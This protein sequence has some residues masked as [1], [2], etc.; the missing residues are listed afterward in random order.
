M[1]L[2]PEAGVLPFVDSGTPMM[3]WSLSIG[4]WLGL[5][6]LRAMLFY[7][8]S[9]IHVEESSSGHSELGGLAGDA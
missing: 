6:I 7:F 5:I 3:M 4:V 2:S 9:V 8:H 1:T